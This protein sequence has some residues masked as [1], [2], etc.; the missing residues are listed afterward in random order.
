MLSLFCSMYFCGRGLAEDYWGKLGNGC[1]GV[2]EP[3]QCLKQTPLKISKLKQRERE[4]LFKGKVQMDLWKESKTDVYQQ[5]RQT[6][7][8]LQ[9]PY[10]WQVQEMHSE[11][12]VSDSKSSSQD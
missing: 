9:I 12:P 10:Y 3:V 7:L 4:M 8:P 11:T 2:C 1:R 6:K 5:C